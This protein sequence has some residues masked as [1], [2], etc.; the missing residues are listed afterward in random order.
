MSS[1]ETLAECQFSDSQDRI[2]G[3]RHRVS[4]PGRLASLLLSRPRPQSSCIFAYITAFQGVSSQLSK[5]SLQKF[6]ADTKCLDQTYLDYGIGRD[7]W[8]QSALIDIPLGVEIRLAA[9]RNL[10]WH[11]RRRV[12]CRVLSIEADT[13]VGRTGLGDAV[14][15][16]SFPSAMQCHACDENNDC[17]ILGKVRIYITEIIR[18]FILSTSISS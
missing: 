13:V 16:E 17:S 14:I 6:K 4:R 9:S 11:S 12:Q 10:F 5:W 3:R 1:W 7:E 8:Y 18:H 2:F 15:R